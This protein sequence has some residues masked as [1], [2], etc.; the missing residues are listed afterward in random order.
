[1]QKKKIITV[2]LFVSIV[3]I[4]LFGY[5][6]F[7][8]NSLSGYTKVPITPS[9]PYS[10]KFDNISSLVTFQNLLP[11]PSGGQNIS[12]QVLVNNSSQG[13]VAIQGAKYSFAGLHIVVS[14][15]T[16]DQLVLYVKPSVAPK[17]SAQDW[18]SYST[19]IL[20]VPMSRFV[21]IDFLEF[22]SSV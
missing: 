17:L 1:M 11:S 19:Y 5:E 12:F 13:F 16:S 20:R 3:V 22:T 14:N 2:V 18:H 4:A 10:I 6:F 7:A 8:A 21:D 9:Q 15:F